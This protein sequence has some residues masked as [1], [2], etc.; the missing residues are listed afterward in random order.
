MDSQVAE[1]EKYAQEKGLR[2]SKEFYFLDQAISGAQLPRPALD[3]LR[4]LA[5]EGLFD[6]VLC[7]SPDRL[8]RKYAHQWILVEELKRSGVSV[9]FV[10]QPPVEDN[11]Q[12]Q[13]LLG[14]QGLFAEYE[15]ALITECLR[16]GK[17][18]RIRRG[19][20]VNPVAPYGYRYIPVSEPN[21]GRWEEH[22][23]EAAVVRHIFREYTE[24][25]GWIL[26]LVAFLNE[27]IACMPPRG[28]R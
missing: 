20:L 18:Y 19:D 26:P 23:I 17:L 27:N 4:D 9:I 10:N 13:L 24:K 12:G 5:V 15:R 28:K 16:R 22:P 3:R 14:I 6:T 7:L 25:G 21:G 2:L 11:P 8:S 1:L